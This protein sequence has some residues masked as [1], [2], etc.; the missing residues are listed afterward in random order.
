MRLAILLAAVAWAALATPVDD[1]QAAFY[2]GA[3]DCDAFSL[4]TRCI[5]AALDG[6]RGRICFID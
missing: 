1:C 5:V 4:F 6:A 2:G 3:A